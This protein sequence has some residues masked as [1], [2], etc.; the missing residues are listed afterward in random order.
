[1]MHNFIGTTDGSY[2]G[3]GGD[4][5]GCLGSSARPPFEDREGLAQALMEAT[6]RLQESERRRAD[7]EIELLRRVARELHDDVG[8]S[9]VLVL[10][11]VQRRIGEKHGAEGWGDVVGE[12]KRVIGAVRDLAYELRPPE[13]EH[14]GLGQSLHTLAT[15]TQQT[16][17]IRVKVDVALRDRPS[18]AKELCVYRVVQGALCNAVR[19]GHASRVRISVGDAS[20]SLDVIVKD[21]GIGYDVTKLAARVASGERVGLGLASM[22]ERVNQCGGLLNIRSAPG[23]GTRVVVRLPLRTPAKMHTRSDRL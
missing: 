7:S 2:S 11:T 1:M 6:E 23:I 12:L 4:V 20:R 17:G 8:Q 19:H 18:A 14:H 10:L 16:G 21:N 9:L 13:L 15:S 22:R 3:I 5:G